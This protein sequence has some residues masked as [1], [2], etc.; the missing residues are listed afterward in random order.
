[1][2]TLRNILKPVATAASI[3]SVLF[4]LVVVPTVIPNDSGFPAPEISIRLFLLLGITSLVFWHR[5]NL[6]RYDYWQRNWYS[7][8]AHIG[9]TGILAS[10]ALCAVFGITIFL[11]Q[12]LPLESAR[13]P[14]A[15]LILGLSL[16]P[17]SYYCGRWASDFL[18][19]DWQ[20]K[21]VPESDNRS[22]YQET[23]SHLLHSPSDYFRVNEDHAVS[24][25]ITWIPLLLM[26]PGL[27]YLCR[28]VYNDLQPSDVVPEVT[29]AV[30][31]IEEPAKNE[32]VLSE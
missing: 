19:G 9:G 2:N 32:P 3:A 27:F 23:Q 7:C 26:L 8:I 16:F 4:L 6:A 17:I 12:R 5:H 28:G 25:Q 11:V 31:Q 10:L 24:Y 22:P 13:G 18:S 15:T 1:M 21:T 29:P 30:E 14:V 20:Q